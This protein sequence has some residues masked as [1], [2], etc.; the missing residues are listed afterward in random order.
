[1]KLLNPAGL[2]LLLGIPVLI[3]I[4]LIKSQHE[5]QAVSST[6]IWKLSTRFMKKRQPLQ[7]LRKILL[8][9][10]QLLIVLTVAILAARPAVISGD[11][12]DYIAIID[13]SASMQTVNEEG[14]SRFRLAVEQV[15]ELAEKIYD[16]HTLSV[17]LA[18]DTAGRIAER[19]TSVNEVR[20]AL[21]VAEA[22]NGGCN[23]E[24]ALADALE[25]C[26]SSNNPKILFYTDHDFPESENVEV[27]RVGGG[28]W[29]LYM[30]G[31][32]IKLGNQESVF[33][34]TV[35]SNRVAS[36]TVGLR[37]DGKVVDAKMVNCAA[38]GGTTVEFK[39]NDV[40]SYDNAEVF[41]QV[42]DDLQ[43]DNSFAVCKPKK[44]TYRVG[45][46]SDTPLYL[47]SAMEA[48][49][50]CTVTCVGAGEADS[51]SGQDLYIYDGVMPTEIPTEGSVLIF[52]SEQMPDGLRADEAVKVA[53]QLQL[54][55]AMEEELAVSFTDTA[56]TEYTPLRGSAAWSPM[57][58]CGED[59]VVM[60]RSRGS[61]RYTAVVGF[62]LHDSNLPLQT[63]F[64]VLMG[65]LVR[66]L[67]P[68]FLKKIDYLTEQQV[69][70]TVL[71]DAKEI[72]VERPD[73]SILS[74]TVYKDVCRLSFSQPGVYTAVMTSFQYDEKPQYV[75]FSVHIPFEE[76]T[77]APGEALV[78]T[79][80]EKDAVTLE[81]AYTES[82]FWL[83]LGILLIVLLEWGWYYREQ[84]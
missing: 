77:D 12:C 45:I 38:E 2:W 32:D 67:V 59:A 25:I 75:D 31:L 20:L 62:D 63:E 29:N 18:S 8:L 58:H 73:G 7:K 66:Y 55:P 16:G 13:A 30:D 3:I 43:L 47:R 48:Q 40:P 37:V 56:V 53:A 61:G 60:L 6:F 76:R 69:T 17:I 28:E 33:T 9:I 42:E 41:A 19:S 44:C 52:N 35:Y 50:N 4:Y 82:W 65:E 72:Y 21:K 70:I 26:Q 27:I 80:P 78:V 71:S 64:V 57:M 5:D 23:T 46:A 24:E 39:V 84:Y 15:D 68:D 81:S 10:L 34:T 14:Q 74:P 1:M 22:K 54:D 79:L 49:G 51:L 11:C 83:A 36:V